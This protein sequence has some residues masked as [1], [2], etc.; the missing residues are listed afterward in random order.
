ML[1]LQRAWAAALLQSPELA[2]SAWE[3]RAAE[4]RRLQAGLL[5][6][7]ELDAEVEDVGGT[8]AYHGTDAAQ[9]TLGIS[10][11]IELGRKRHWRSRVAELDRDLAGWD[12]EMKRV[13]V[14]T[15]TARRF[16]AVL[17]AQRR[18]ELAQDNARLA[19]EVMDATDKRIK[20]GTISPVEHDR[21]RVE[22]LAAEM[23]LERTRTLLTVARERL[24]ASWGSTDPRFDAVSGEL[25][26]VQAIPSIQQLKSVVAQNPSV[27]RW[28]TEMVRR[29]AMVDAAKAQRIPDLSL[30][31]GVRR[32]ND[33]EDNAFVFGVSFPLPLFDRNQGEVRAAQMEAAG[34]DAS[35]R[36]T[37]VDV[38]T[39]LASAYADLSNARTAAV[40]L[41]E[42]TLPAA[43]RVF[44][45]TRKAFAQGAMNYIEVLDAQHTLIGIRSEYLEALAEYHEAK[46]AVEGLIGQSLD[47]ILGAASEETTGNHID[48][49]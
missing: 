48:E 25:D 11:L 15:E 34:A 33:S 42:E 38:K 40:V 9:T 2:G 22:T 17:A 43:Q 16:I 7:P 28:T 3:V 21:Q 35:R 49:E 27:A 14:L 44:E 8:G 24:A 45:A 13:E 39:A 41:H 4:A 23:A 10:Q 5:P 47:S 29:Q 26:A 32:Y 12:Y 30:G 18:L 19:G 20:A 36:A 6:N 31:A 37:E 46:A 1:T